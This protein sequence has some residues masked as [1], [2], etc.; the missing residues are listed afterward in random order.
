[1]RPR[2]FG[3]LPSGAKIMK[4][5]NTEQTNNGQAREYFSRFVVD[6]RR[7]SS[8]VVKEIKKE[9]KKLAQELRSLWPKLTRPLH[10]IEPNL[11][12]RRA[13]V[14]T[15]GKIK[16]LL[17][18]ILMAGGVKKQ[19]AWR[20]FLKKQAQLLSRPIQ[21]SLAKRR[22]KN[23]R[24]IFGLIRR[25]PLISFALVLILIILPFKVLS[26]WQL[27]DLRDWQA[28]ILKRSE[29]AMSNLMAA[30]DSVSRR[31]FRQADNNFQAAGADFLSATDD[32]NQV[33]DGLLALAALSNDPK[34]KVAA[35]S[36]KFLMAGALAASLGQHLIAA[37]DTLFNGDRSDFPA[38]LDKFL[39]AGRAAVTDARD[40]KTSLNK[41]N[42]DNLPEAY[43]QKF[44][45]LSVQTS[46]L[47]D[48]LT[49]FVSAA[50][51]FQGILGLSRD[52]RYLL[53]FQNNAELRA[54]GGFIGSYALLDLHN[55][56]IRNLEVPGGGSY[57]TE[58]GLKVRIA[59][60]QPLWLVS[61]LWHFWD[62]NWWPDW[63]MT[64]RN[65]MWFYQ[66]SDGP[67]VDGVIGV[68]PT[69][70]E[71]LLEI[72]GPIDLTPEYGLTITADNFWETVQTIT[73]QKNLTKNYPGMSVPLTTTTSPLQTT[74]P[75]KQD[76]TTNAAN[77]PKKIIG[78]LL[79]KIMEILPQKLDQNNLI[80]I[81]GLFEDSLSEKQ[82]L[83]YFTD[84]ALESEMSNRNW[85]GEIKD[86][87][88]DYLLV[89]DTNIAGQKSDRLMQ[90]QIDQS[91][92]I[93][94]AGRIIN[95]LKITRTHTGQKN[96]PLTG[97]RNVDWLRVYVPAGSELLSAAGFRQPE[98][99]YFQAR[100]DGELQNLP[101]LAAENSARTDESSGTKIYSEKNKTVFA[102]WVM[103][104]PGE[105]VEI[106]LKYRLPF[107]FWTA[108]PAG[109]NWLKRFSRWLNPEAP[110]L[111]AY[112]LLLQKQPG[113]LPAQFSSR[114]ILPPL[115]EIFWRHPE[116]LAGTA[117]WQTTETLNG[118][119]Y[120]S[121][122]VQKNK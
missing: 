107:N 49:N 46:L 97:V 104:D 22:P 51:K 17:A 89:V 25:Q 114:L 68:T 85:G 84:P 39:I 56:Q 36:K 86:T 44:T 99:K 43:R 31:D 91:S 80:K 113:S 54:S 77:K 117:G 64:A 45:S 120:W 23:P 57:D 66:K 116:D 14:R 1:M 78:D 82:I 29:M 96:E 72:T 103:V 40:L 8:T 110:E 41:I 75:L 13:A 122:L 18:K 109:D 4:L 42:P 95:T 92:E 98:T 50:E 32:L 2:N 69:V 38:T 76:L 93:D 79:A 24:N 59:A 73:E 118:D 100:P 16:K 88:R 67:S 53:V 28:Q 52:K 48:S 12:G 10:K 58:A 55:G 101:E 71:R 108:S 3:G 33:N 26:A 65:L 62:A 83:F 81:I 119:K 112:S 35:E 20:G 102:N 5:K 61:P 11:L 15:G 21:T 19:P 74:L 47:S 63:P 34:I 30:A 27:F 90:E 115:T 7:P 70:L 6:L 106:I 121:I 60:P 111:L 9:E 94:A 87:D 37:T 105:T